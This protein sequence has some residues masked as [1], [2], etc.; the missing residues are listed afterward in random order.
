[1][2]NK[3]Y[4][5]SSNPCN[6]QIPPSGVWTLTGD[7]TRHYLTFT[8]SGTAMATV[9]SS[10]QGVI[11][12]ILLRQY[13]S[14]PLTA[15]TFAGRVSGQLRALESNANADMMP[16]V[17]LRIVSNDGTTERG[18]LTNFVT[19]VLEYTTSTLTN[20][21]QPSGTTLIGSSSQDGDRLV[22]EYG[23]R[24]NA[25][26]ANRTFSQR[27]GDALATADLPKDNAD[28]NDS[29]PWIEFTNRI[30]FKYTNSTTGLARISKKSNYSK[31]G[32]GA[33]AV[34]VNKNNAGKSR[35]SVKSSKLNSGKGSIVAVVKKTKDGKARIA[36]TSPKTL[37]GKSRISSNP[38]KLQTGIARIQVS[39]KK[40]ITGLASISGPNRIQVCW[41]QLQTP[42]IAPFPVTHTV[43]S[44][45][46]IQK[47][48]S[49][50]VSGKCLLGVV[51]SKN[52]SALASIFNGYLLHPSSDIS[53]NGWTIAPLYS[54]IDETDC[55]T[56]DYISS[57]GDPSNEMCEVKL[58]ELSGVTYSLLEVDYTYKKDVEMGVIDL[59]ISLY[60]GT[61]LIAEQTLT[62]ISTT[63]TTGSFTLTAGQLSSISD[64][65]NLRIRLEANLSG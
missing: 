19:G 9:Q 48:T 20:R 26:S 32:K 65:T 34:K 43:S 5:P 51:T 63:W 3:F 1:M 7:M 16:A 23:A 11:N 45:T 27:Y 50:T 56:S 4:L 28:T 60:Q 49:Y 6:I 38:N 12:N 35:V 46:R 41:A 15:Q 8:G 39:R 18:I 24:Q 47:K 2:A 42:V 21:M 55:D 31:S 53:V 10:S 14:P 30:S 17:C 54:K 57:P 40:T 44:L 25:T 64:Y 36:K 59:K 62:N 22:I 52:T 13:V 33:I 58:N 37:T 29:L 61:T